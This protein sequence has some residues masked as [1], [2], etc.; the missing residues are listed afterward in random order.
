MP[1]L[2]SYSRRMMS[3]ERLS[4]SSEVGGGG[5]MKA[6]MSY[7]PP[8]ILRVSAYACRSW[9]WEE[10]SMESD[11]KKKWL[12]LGTIFGNG[13][14]REK[15]LVRN[16]LT[17]EPSGG[18]GMVRLAMNESISSPSSRCIPSWRSAARVK[19]WLAPPCPR[20]DTEEW[21]EVVL[22]LREL[23]ETL[24]SVSLAP[25]GSNVHQECYFTLIRED[26]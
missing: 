9:K 26:Y 11:K 24:S 25:A 23:R 5:M 8:P 17:T 2:A 3:E 13:N 4:F 16:K 21:S 6:D 7:S 18:G 10:F 22:V 15:N 14:W 19:F 20:P 12:W 1:S